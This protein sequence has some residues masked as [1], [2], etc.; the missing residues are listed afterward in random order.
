MDVARDRDGEWWIIELGDGQVSGLP[1]RADPTALFA[2][3]LD[4]LGPG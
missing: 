2:P 3:L 4:R 1:D